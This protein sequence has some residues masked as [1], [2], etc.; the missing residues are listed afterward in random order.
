[1]V[2]YPVRAALKPF[3]SSLWYVL[4]GLISVEAIISVVLNL[5]TMGPILLQ[6]LKAQDMYLAASFIVMLSVLTVIG[7][8][9]SDILLATLYP[10]IRYQ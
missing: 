9:I 3:V 2:R 8:L 10:R 4:V 6:A 7:T 5:P 1:M